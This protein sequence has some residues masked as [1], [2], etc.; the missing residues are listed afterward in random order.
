MPANTYGISPSGVS[1]GKRT[2]CFFRQIENRLKA[3]RAVEVTVQIGLGS[4]SMRFSGA[5][6]QRSAS[7]A[8]GKDRGGCRYSTLMNWLFCS[9]Q[10]AAPAQLGQQLLCS[11]R[12]QM[13][14]GAG[15]R[16]SRRESSTQ[17][18]RPSATHQ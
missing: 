5:M 18:H 7:K 14:V 1:A 15:W 11:L 2:P 10:V 8:P 17:R 13:G 9:T 12:T 3:Q 16:C 6:A 4:F